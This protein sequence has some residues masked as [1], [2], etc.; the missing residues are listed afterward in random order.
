MVR[1]FSIHAVADDLIKHNPL[2]Q[3]VS[4]NTILSDWTR[5]KTW[6]HLVVR[7]D[8]DTILDETIGSIREASAAAWM[9]YAKAPNSNAKIGALRTI[10]E[11]NGKLIDI[12]QSIGAVTKAPIEIKAMGPSDEDI[13]GNLTE[14][15]RRNLIAASEAYA[16]A[17]SQ[18]KP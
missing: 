15:E 1:G 6:L 5:R 14:D 11:A 9:E 12:M 16:R 10:L 7:P 17:R 4:I 3:N 13:W 8:D 2:F 18:K